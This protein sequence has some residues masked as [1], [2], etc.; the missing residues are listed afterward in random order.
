ML[1]TGSS[2]AAWSH[3]N[4]KLYKLVQCLSKRPA[5]KQEMKQMQR[6]KYAT[7]KET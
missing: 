2:L 7:Y 4:K 1:V 6:R 3:F 5:E